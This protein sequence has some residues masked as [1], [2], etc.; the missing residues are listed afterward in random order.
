MDE[1]E[2]RMLERSLRDTCFIC[3]SGSPTFWK[4]RVR[5]AYV[6]WIRKIQRVVP[7]S[8]WEGSPFDVNRLLDAA[9]L[10]EVSELL[11]QH[12]GDFGSRP[13]DERSS[14][15]YLFS[16]VKWLGAQRLEGFEVATEQ[17]FQFLEIDRLREVVV[18]AGLQTSFPVAIHG[19]G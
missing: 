10:G 3:Y 2:S 15:F 9:D 7:G 18:H 14:W 19:I 11:Q 4:V 12:R 13:G 17:G 8:A 6:T 16:S 5:P 1:W